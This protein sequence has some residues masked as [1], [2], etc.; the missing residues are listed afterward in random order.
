MRAY[1]R[2]VRL[3]TVVLVLYG[4]LVVVVILVLVAGYLLCP[5]SRRA[6]TIPFRC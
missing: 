5:D 2:T 6:V 3:L 4:G 1:R